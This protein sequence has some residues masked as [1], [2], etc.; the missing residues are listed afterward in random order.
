MQSE[1]DSFVD[2]YDGSQLT[3][4]GD[5]LVSPRGARY[6]IVRG[7]PRFVSSENYAEA[8]GEQ[9]T[10]FPNTQ[11]DSHTGLDFSERQLRG[12][13]GSDLSELRGRRVLEVGCGPGR[14][15]EILL[16][17]GAIVDAFDYSVA[18]DANARN[19]GASAC[20]RIAQADVRHLPYPPE[21]YDYI[22]AMGVI[23][24]TPSPEES[25]ASLWRALKPGG[26]FVMDHYR[27]KIRNYLPA[28]IGTAVAAYR[29]YFL[30][31]PASRRFATIK[32]VFDFWFPIVWRFRESRLAQY[33]IAR[34][35]PIVCR[36]PSYGLT[37]REM[38][39]DWMLLDLHDM[40]TD[41][42]KHRRT[43]GGV[44]RMLETLGARDIDV[45]PGMNGVE[46]RC[47]K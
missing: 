44:R 16:K 28:P 22:V 19:N 41:V 10:R 46:A 36:Y 35:S 21:S 32:R 17:H 42:Y 3:P 30:R 1:F 26:A 45:R 43:V 9:W 31:V 20:L 38:Y 4:D 13:F 7:I 2:P 15:T 11:L 5:S 47:R 12:A 24:H 27:A 23:Q 39:Y 29:W 33:V 18:V 6:P 8:F 37:T 34:F 25:L 40:G 14:Y